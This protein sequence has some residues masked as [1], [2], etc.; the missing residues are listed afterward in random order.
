MK[1]LLT[2]SILLGLVCAVLIG[3]SQGFPACIEDKDLEVLIKKLQQDVARAEATISSLRAKYENIIKQKK[4]VLSEIEQD[5]SKLKEKSVPPKAVKPSP[6]KSVAARSKSDKPAIS[7]GK[8]RPAPV[9]VQAVTKKETEIEK[10]KRE[11]AELL[12]AQKAEVRKAGEEE[13]KKRR[14][15]F[16]ESRRIKDAKIKE[17]EAERLAQKKIRDAELEKKNKESERAKALLK[18][19]LFQEARDRQ[20]ETALEK[21]KKINERFDIDYLDGLIKKQKDLCAA[22]IQMQINIA[23]EENNLKLL[24][25]IRSQKERVR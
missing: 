1:R 12:A 22:I 6:V 16:E 2:I 10:K 21:A 11:L 7:A 5:R 20:I 8:F 17:A 25:E 14:L 3:V 4:Q 9:N 13:S 24:K 15:A 19:K 23:E 18:E